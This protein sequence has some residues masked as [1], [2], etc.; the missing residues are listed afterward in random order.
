MQT[1]SL[2]ELRD[3]ELRLIEL[4]AEKQ[5]LQTRKLELLDISSSTRK[6][7][8]KTLSREAGKILFAEIRRQS[9]EHGKA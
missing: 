6:P 1:P 5:H 9:D 2:A 8:R 4:E 3:I 7:A